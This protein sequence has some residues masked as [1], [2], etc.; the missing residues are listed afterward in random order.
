MVG[1]IV[2]A[3]LLAFIGGAFA[4]YFYCLQSKKSL[5][6]AQQ[7]MLDALRAILTK[8]HGVEIP[9][10]DAPKPAS[11]NVYEMGRDIV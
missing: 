9:D 10:P 3:F 5:F 1:Y 4:G 7:I 6:S 8:D 2:A 11:M